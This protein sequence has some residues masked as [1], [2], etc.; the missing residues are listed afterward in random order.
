MAGA[1]WAAVDDARRAAGLG[2]LVA[3][4]RDVAWLDGGTVGRSIVG[5][6]ADVVVE[7]DD[8]AAIQAVERMWRREPD[9]IWTGCLSYDFA[10]DLVLGRTPTKRSLPG[11]S[12]RRHRAALEID[13]HGRVRA[14]GDV[15]ELPRQGLAVEG[16]WPL[17]SLAAVWSPADYRA[18][19]AAAQRHIIAGDTYQVNLA[20]RF[21]APWRTRCSTD[22]LAARAA[23][24][25]LRLRAK[26]P[27]ERGALLHVPGGLVLSNS[28][29]TLVDVDRMPDGT[30][31]ARA[32]PIKGTRPR[33]ASEAADRAAAAEL[34][35]S[36]KD[37]AEHVMIVDLVRN[38]LGRLALAGSV[39]APARPD[40]LALPTVHHLV[41]E[42][43]ATLR[44]DVGLAELCAAL[45]PGGSVTGA[46][47]RRTLEIIE[48]LEEHPR[49]IYCGAIVLLEPTGLRMSIPIRTAFVDTRGMSLHAGGGIVVDSEPEAERLECHAK[50]RAFEPPT[51]V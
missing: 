34:A 36:A 7:A 45:V 24:L 2:R 50:I 22:E 41:S 17:A 31:I 37:L 49:G 30:S 33:G 18:R 28:P 25:Y 15:P 3:D 12:L 39:S 10:A 26:A 51:G 6:D 20:Q 35:V 23:S 14:H 44:P 43:R 42:V 21:F 9:A 27:A 8:L 16:E 32:R 13:A 38:D 46:P 19:V 1:S 29:E 47:K 5:F 4:G 40:A 48:A 11:V